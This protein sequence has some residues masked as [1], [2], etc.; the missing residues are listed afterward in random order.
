MLIA[1]RRDAATNANALQR[2]F[3]ALIKVRLVSQYCHGGMVIDGTLYQITAAHGLQEIGPGAWTPSRWRLIDIGGDDA[4]ALAEWHRIKTPPAGWRGVV[5]RLLKG[6]DHFGLLAF[7]G[8]P[9]TVA[10]LNYCFEVCWRMAGHR[11]TGRVTPE[12]LIDLAVP[13]ARAEGVSR[14]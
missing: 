7:V 10:W 3:S 8:V 2:I 11:V 9:N 14:G 6:Y 13:N 12:M 5:W 1:L 4:D